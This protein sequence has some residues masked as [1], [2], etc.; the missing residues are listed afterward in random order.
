[1]PFEYGSF[2]MTIFKMPR[3][4]PENYL[5]LFSSLKA[6]Q[7]DQV[8]D[9]PSIGWVSGRHLLESEIDDA[10]ALCGGHLYLNLRTAERKIPATLLN[11]IC[12]RAELAYMQENNAMKVPPKEK[13]RIKQE[14]VEKNLKKMPPTISGIPMV[15]DMASN[16]LYVGTG[17]TAQLDNFL[18]VFL[19]T[20]EVEPFHLNVEEM[21]GERIHKLPLVS[22]SEETS[23]DNPTPARDFL[24][25]LW[26]YSEMHGG[27][28][29]HKQFGDFEI[30]IEGPLTFSFS[31]DDTKG[32]CETAVKK[33]NPLL[34]AEAKAALQVGKKLK[35]AKFTMARGQE[36]WKGSVDIDK[37]AFSGIT[38]PEG[39]EMERESSFQERI[40]FL[41]I[42]SE[43]MKLYFEKFVETV[44]AKEWMKTEKEIQKWVRERDSY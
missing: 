19:K 22:F 4:L 12:K 44:T 35:K 33:G 10:T 15:L 26:F 40:E 14:A 28:V 16:A 41:N 20:T 18:A 3:N 9:E 2:A 29:T 43:A 13:K 7:L 32:S 37:F 25:W 24:T 17:S 39:E 11:A 21:L 34:S 36:I 30:M 23:D 8:G 1:M 38:L 31:S 5:E 27:K 42:F 6:G